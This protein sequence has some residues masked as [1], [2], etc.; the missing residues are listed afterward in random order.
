LVLGCSNLN[1]ACEVSVQR[2]GGT[3][4][5]GDAPVSRSVR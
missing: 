5:V 2:L 3:V 1:A 4:G